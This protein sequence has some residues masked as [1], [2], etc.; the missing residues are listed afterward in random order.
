MED[1]D[2]EAQL[3]LQMASCYRGLGRAAEAEQ[4]YLTITRNDDHNREARIELAKMYEAIGM[5]EKAFSYVNEVLYLERQEPDERPFKRRRTGIGDISA[6]KLDSFL[7]PSQSY[8][9]N[10]TKSQT[11]HVNGEKREER[12]RL[13][14]NAVRMQYIRLQALE[15]HMQFGDENATEEWIEAANS[16]VDDFRSAKVFYPWDR[17]LKFL[18]YS[19][20]TR[21]R[22]PKSGSDV[23][24]DMEAM[25][26]RLQASI[27]T[28]PLLDPSFDLDTE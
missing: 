27:G 23:I 19:R 14:E 16:M 9:G 13:L 8:R 20:A 24:A 26:E 17:Y 10:T 21:G 25:G 4:C 1:Y 11:V 18:G 5:P 12:E 15:D 28:L 2:D 3:Y 6:G 22:A 7:P